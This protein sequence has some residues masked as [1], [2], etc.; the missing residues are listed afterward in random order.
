MRATPIGEH[1]D[2]IDLTARLAEMGAELLVVALAKFDELKG[3]EQDHK[4][5]TLAPKLTREMGQID[6]TSIAPE[7][8]DRRVR[9]LQPWPG[10]SFPPIE[11]RGPMKVLRG[12]VIDGRYQPELVQFPGKK[13]VRVFHE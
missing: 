13:P 12:Q 9:A 11:G 1:E 5:A 8:I 3:V 7:E 2:A 4:L 6:P 10:V